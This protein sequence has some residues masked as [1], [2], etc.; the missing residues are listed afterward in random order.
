MTVWYDQ[1]PTHNSQ[2]TRKIYTAYF[3]TILTEVLRILLQLILPPILLAESFDN[4]TLK[5]VAAINVIVWS[6]DT[7]LIISKWP[8]K[9]RPD[10]TNRYQFFYW[11]PGFFFGG[12]VILEFN[13]RDVGDRC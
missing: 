9:L 4:F 7:L 3:F 6:C 1:L 12:L 8:G 13:P 5:Y 2:F 11:H 10:L